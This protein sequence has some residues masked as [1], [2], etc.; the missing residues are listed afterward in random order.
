MMTYGKFFSIKDSSGK[1]YFVGFILNYSSK[2]CITFK[3]KTPNVK[4]K[5]MRCKEVGNLS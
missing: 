5:G 4:S 3:F 2:Q 1:F